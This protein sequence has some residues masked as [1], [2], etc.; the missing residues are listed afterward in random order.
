M[1][2]A[3]RTLALLI[4]AVTLA[5][6]CTVHDSPAPSLTGPSELSLALTMAATPDT[7]A[8]DGSSQTL[9]VVVARD[10]GGRAV[11]NLPIRFDVVRDKKDTTGQ[12][13]GE[14]I[15]DFGVLST[16]TALT[17]GDGRAQ[18]F[19][20]APAPPLSSPTA[21]PTSPSTV[22]V[23]ATP[24][25]A[26]YANEVARSVEIRLVPAG[27]I[28]DPGTGPVAA[29]KVD[30]TLMPSTVLSARSPGVQVVF[31]ASVSASP[32]GLGSYA[33]DFG[34]GSTGAGVAVQH[35]YTVGGTYYVRLTVT[36]QKGQT[37][38]A[39]YPV[40]VAAGPTALFTWTQA[41]PGAPVMFNGGASWAIPPAGIASY[42][43]Y[44]GQALFASGVTPPPRV[45]GPA[46]TYSVTLVVTD[47]GG[48]V[49]RQTQSVTV[50]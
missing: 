45:L 48:S 2:R 26:N 25:G 23:R 15:V 17:G 28:Y 24:T 3:F 13:V 46:G 44:V 14:E 35:T 6:A 10:V 18:V 9:V 39:T 29:F 50:K 27:A 5:A 12:I 43:W 37:A 42:D 47:T 30:G 40:A 22:K 32:A 49:G 33:W 20:T 7:V 4:S 41:T 31:D 19:Y 36:D 11:A 8:Q 21:P 1:A 16:K 34:D 38:W